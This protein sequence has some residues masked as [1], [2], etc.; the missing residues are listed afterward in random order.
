MLLP[1]FNTITA[2]IIGSC[3]VLLLTH[4][5]AQVQQLPLLTVLPA[6][7]KILSRCFWPLPSATAVTCVQTTT[8]S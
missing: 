2:F 6:A 8:C 1:H 5:A 4:M 7:R 3:T